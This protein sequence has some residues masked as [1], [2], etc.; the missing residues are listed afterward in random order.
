M[1]GREGER[2]S[3]RTSEGRPSGER[4]C[5]GGGE[6][7]RE[8]DASRIFRRLLRS[9][10]RCIQCKESRQGE[11]GKREAEAEEGTLSS[12]AESSGEPA[13]HHESELPPV[14]VG[15]R[16]QRIACSINT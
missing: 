2:R 11:G 14:K 10:L 16:G 5:E 6:G 1:K 7:A 13:H 9:T 8:G 3:D 4:V 15:Q 12:T